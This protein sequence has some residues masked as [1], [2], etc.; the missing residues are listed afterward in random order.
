MGQRVRLTG[1]GRTAP[2]VAT[3]ESAGS[4]EALTELVA[5]AG[6]RGVLARGLGRSYGDA[7][8]N[9]GGTVVDLRTRRRIGPVGADGVVEV[10]GGASLEEMLVALLPQGWFLPVT[11]GTRQV[12]VGGAIAA[13]VHGKNHHVDGS[14]GHHVRWLDLL[15]GDGQVRRLTGDD[16]LFWATVGGMGLTGIV[17]RAGVAMT[18]VE[19]SRCLVDTRRCADLD[20]TMAAMADDD[21]YP[22]SVAWVDALARGRHLGRGVLTQGRF[23]RRDELP[24]ADRSDPLAFAPRQLLTTPDLAPSGLLNQ[25]TV[26][27]FN[28]MWFRKAPAR[29]DGEVQALT[30]FFHPLDAVALWNRIYGPRGFLQYQVLVPDEAREVI[31]TCLATSGTDRL[32]SFLT[33]LKR[34]GPGNPGHLSFPGPGWTLTLD[35]PVGD[36][37]LRPT[38]A[39]LDELV[40]DAGGRSYLAKDSRMHPEVFRRMYPRTPQWQE[41]RHRA[42]PR[43]VFTS[44]LARRLEL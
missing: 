18:P 44:D 37:R 40:V 3:L 12:T 7:A 42:D 24:G 23:A 15:C 8:Q 13:D 41:I 36:P 34:M 32:P 4:D 28:E 11:P 27:A 2:S 20:E 21:D 35:L 9:G 17:L 30:Q 43:G 19:T 16:E 22:F 5:T 29:R 31:R 39:R 26:A 38:L 6:P 10:E 33:V 25:F 14:F 1:W